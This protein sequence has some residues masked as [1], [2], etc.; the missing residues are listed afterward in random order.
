[1]ALLN[2]VGADDD[3]DDRVKHIIHI[4]IDSFRYSLTFTQVVLLAERTEGRTHA[5]KWTEMVQH[6]FNDTVLYYSCCR[7]NSMT[8]A[9]TKQQRRPS[10]WPL[11]LC[12]RYPD[13]AIGCCFVTVLSLHHPPYPIHSL[14]YLLLIIEIAP[15]NHRSIEVAI[16]P[17]TIYTYPVTNTTSPAPPG[18]LIIMRDGQHFQ[19]YLPAL[20]CRSHRRLYSLLA[21]FYCLLMPFIPLLNFAAKVSV[22]VPLLFTF[23]YLSSYFHVKDSMEILFAHFSFLDHRCALQN[24]LSLYC[25]QSHAE[26]N[27]V[28]SDAKSINNKPPSFASDAHFQSY[29]PDFDI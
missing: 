26:L 24:Y 22:I 9:N 4:I 7:C 10:L 14:A 23:A 3:D 17:A 8:T 28:S 18:T 2:D 16:I 19:G 13:V 11:P 25:L 20:Y 21:F 29:Q 15:V 1:M 5:C 12:L 27:Q 6:T